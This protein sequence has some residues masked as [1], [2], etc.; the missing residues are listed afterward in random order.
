MSF[1]ASTCT[2]TVPNGYYNER[3]V[4]V[5][6][7]IPDGYT[8]NPAVGTECWISVLANFN[9]PVN[10]TTTWAAAILGNPIRLVE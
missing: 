3:I 7:P 2:L 4:T 5:D 1:N 9:G 6:L 8:C 10:D